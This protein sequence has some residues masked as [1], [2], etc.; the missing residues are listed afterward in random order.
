MQ[1]GII[2]IEIKSYAQAI[3]LLKKALQY[4]WDNKNQEAE[5]FIY[6]YMGN[7]YYY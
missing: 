7:A 5:L 2:A 3:L 6:D 1:L 4:A